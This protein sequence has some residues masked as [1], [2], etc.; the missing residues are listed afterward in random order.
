MLANKATK[1]AERAN[2]EAQ[3]ANAEWEIAD[4]S[5]KRSTTLSQLSDAR[6][7]SYQYVFGIDEKQS[8]LSAKFLEYLAN[9]DAVE[10]ENNPSAYAA[11]R[12]VIGK[13]FLDRNDYRR[14]RDVLEPWVAEEYGNPETLAYGQ[15][16]LGHVYVE[17]G[18]QVQ[19]LSLFKKAE[20]YY[21]GTPFENTMEHTAMAIQVALLSDDEKE[22]TRVVGMIDALMESV[23]NQYNR[24]FLIGR[25]YKLQL[26]QGNFNAAYTALKQ[27][28]Q[29]VEAGAL[30][31]TASLD[32]IFLNYASM[33]IFYS[34]E[35]FLAKKNLDVAREIT[36]TR[37]G[38]SKSLGYIYEL[39]ADLSWIEQDYKV[40]LPKNILAL[41]LLEKYAGKSEH[42]V[43]VLAKQAVIQADTKNFDAA[44]LIL[45]ELRALSEDVTG[46][47]PELLELYISARKEGIASAQQITMD[48]GFPRE[49]IEKK[50][51]PGYFLKR[52]QEDGLKL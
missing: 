7:D 44:G 27:Q 24:S 14:A 37:K 48:P 50:L 36:E 46:V 3:R 29:M 30:G 2:Q 51:V 10:K 23:T 34:N 47:W 18:M 20:Q 1:E 5:M 45:Q 39:E 35:L 26:K 6:A 43:G 42:Y 8:D 11:K 21:I 38:E 25:I 41:E 22:T 4:W 52:L 16:L 9:I 31:K 12:F 19:A 32:T 40:A 49:K 13:H 28:V 33:N 15:T 17:F